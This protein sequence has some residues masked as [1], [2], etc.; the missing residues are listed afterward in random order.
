MILK[1]G[2]KRAVELYNHHSNTRNGRQIISFFAEHGASKWD[3]EWFANC[4]AREGI[5]AYELLADYKDWKRYVLSYYKK[6]G[7][8]AP[9]LN[10]LPH[11]QTI[12]IID[13][14]K[15]F[16]AKPNPLYDK[17]GVYMGIFNSFQDA[18]MLPISTSW[19]V[20][21]TPKRYDEFCSNGKKGL[22]IIN[23][24]NEP[25]YRDVIVMINKGNVEYWDSTNSR[26]S[27]IDD[28]IER[29]ENY[30]R[31]IPN[32]AK[33]IIYNIAA[34]QTEQIENNQQN[35]NCNRIRQ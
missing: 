7:K 5:K 35:I 30:E 24:N 21:K 32:E 19:C 12:Q 27:E 20:T 9:N 11:S 17:N 1:E 6:I 28:E 2:Y 26:M 10:K 34:N 14:C 4:S 8:Q 23:N 25:P 15:R 3:L 16:F 31:T 13:S 18:N 22:Y 33:Q 29:F